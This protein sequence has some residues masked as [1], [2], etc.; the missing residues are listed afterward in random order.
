MMYIQVVIG[1]VLLLGGAELL[2]RG[3]VAVRAD[4]PQ[5]PVVLKSLDVG[6]ERNGFS[7][8]KKARDGE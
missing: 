7:G 4:I 1:F 6:L 3:A 5:K 2:V 8:I